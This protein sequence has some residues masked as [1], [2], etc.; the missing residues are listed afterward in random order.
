MVAYQLKVVLPTD[1]LR[2]GR[3]QPRPFI[4][5]GLCAGS[6]RQMGLAPMGGSLASMS[7]P[8]VT[9]RAISWLNIR[10]LGTGP[11]PPVNTSPLVLF[12]GAIRPSPY[13]ETLPAHRGVAGHSRTAPQRSP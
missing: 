13:W 1:A 5:S 7:A 9:A 8:Q 3:G 12:R 4:S 6:R 2:E 10:L 11:G